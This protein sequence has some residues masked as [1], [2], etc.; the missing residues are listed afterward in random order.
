MSIRRM[1]RKMASAK[2]ATTEPT[3][4]KV[5]F[6]Q[7]TARYSSGRDGLRGSLLGQAHLLTDALR[8]L[9]RVLVILD[10]D[11]RDLS[12]VGEA[13]LQHVVENVDAP[14]ELGLH[15]L[16]RHVPHFHDLIEQERVPL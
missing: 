5:V 15:L 3:A 8:R 10:D 6:I 2:A 12:E 4:A 7:A 9:V 16:M 1:N 13:L 14:L 11:L